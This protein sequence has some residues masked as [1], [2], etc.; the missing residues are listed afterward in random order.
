MCMLIVLPCQHRVPHYNGLVT[1]NTWYLSIKW[2]ADFMEHSWK[3]LAQIQIPRT[4]CHW[5]LNIRMGSIY[6]DCQCRAF[7]RDFTSW[8]LRERCI[9]FRSWCWPYP[10]L[11][12]HKT[13]NVNMKYWAC[14]IWSQARTCMKAISHSPPLSI[15]FGIYFPQICQKSCSAHMSRNLEK[16]KSVVKFEFKERGRY[17]AE[18]CRSVVV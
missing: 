13:P 18:L 8:T 12:S 6:S 2:S 7:T 5:M 4:S 15:A 16:V 3:G 9:S 17:W 1:L 11:P 10:I 14:N